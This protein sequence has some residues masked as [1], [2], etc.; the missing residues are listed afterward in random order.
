M[1]VSKPTILLSH[2]PMEGMSV[3]MRC[4]VEK[5]TE[6][7]NFTWEQESQ[8]G[9]ITTLAKENSSVV[10]FN[11][12]SRNHTGWFR[13]LVRNEVNQ[14]RS[15]RIWLNVLCESHYVILLTSMLSTVLDTFYIHVSFHM[16]ICQDQAWRIVDKFP[17]D[18]FCLDRGIRM[19]W[20]KFWLVD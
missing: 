4:F 10:S 12:V 17:L 16:V 20:T 18:E 15:D 11:R 13:C 8:T 9:M 19:N 5:G 6:P 2:S 14:Q 7:I 3:S 1:P